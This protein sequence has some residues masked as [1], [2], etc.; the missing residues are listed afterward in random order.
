MRMKEIGA[1]GLTLV[2]NW[3]IPRLMISRTFY[4]TYRETCNKFLYHKH[5][6]IDLSWYDISQC[7]TVSKM[8]CIAFNYSECKG[9]CDQPHCCAICFQFGHNGREHKHTSPLQSVS[10]RETRWFFGGSLNPKL[11]LY[12]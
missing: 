11:M 6:N 8:F 2:S 5:S 7:V 10:R 3:S 4:V 12:D 9:S 1:R